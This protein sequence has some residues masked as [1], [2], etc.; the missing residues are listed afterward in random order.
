MAKIPFREEVYVESFKE[1]KKF[2][3]AGDMGGTNTNFGI[4][5]LDTKNPVL[6]FSVH[7][8]SK[9]IESFP[10][11]VKHLC[12]YIK[13]EYN[14]EIDNSVF[15][16]AGVV[17]QNRLYAQPTNTKW[18]IDV[19]EIKKITGIKNLILIN[20]FEAVGFGIESVDPKDIAIINQGIEIPKAQRACLG[21]GT[22]LGKSL[23]IWSESLNMYIPQPSEGGHA[24]FIVHDKEEFGFLEFMQKNIAL[25]MAIE[26]NKNCVI[27]WEHVLSGIGIQYIYLYLKEIRK[28][29]PN[30]YS[31]EI[32]AKDFNPDRISHFAQVDPQSKETFL[33][34]SKFYARCAKNLAL[35]MLT[36]N[37]IYIAGGI[38]AKNL[39]VF[40]DQVFMD[41]FLAC[42]RQIDLLKN[43]PIKIILDYNVSLYGA[44]VAGKHFGIIK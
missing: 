20:D 43:I 4:F 29:K 22:G 28:Y 19:N 18:P 9:E 24:D 40:Q 7:Y 34:Y 1:T 3:L 33:W 23:L 2:F 36:L 13:S 37:G 41:E 42:N 39:A 6:L 25:P 30:Q 38:A 15:G 26:E 10:E 12:D 35:D 8:K 11:T 32:E 21:A 14:I 27:S 5:S 17:K 31:Q 44:V 16:A